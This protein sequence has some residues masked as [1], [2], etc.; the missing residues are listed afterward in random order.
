M[1]EAIPW[2][3]LLPLFWAILA[4]LLGP[5]RGAMPAVTGLAV[6]LAL[7]LLLAASRVEVAQVQD[8]GG[9]DAPLGIEL[10]ADGFSL[11]MLLMT[12]AVALLI[13]LYASAYFTRH[14][15][16]HAYFWPLAGCLIAAMNALYLSSD[17]FNL[18]V[19]LELLSLAAIGLVASEGNAKSAT[20]ALRYLFAS[21]MGSGAYLLGVA[22]LYGAYGTVSLPHLAELMTHGVSAI[23]PYSAGLMLLGLLL[24]TALFPLHFWLPPAHGGA[25]APVSAL[26]SALVIKASFYLALRLWTTLFEPVT[27]MPA[28]QLLGMLG[29]G[30]VLWGSFQALRQRRLKMLVAYSTVAQIGYLFLVFPLLTGSIQSN[31]PSAMQGVILQAVSHGFAKAAMFG[32]A[33]AVILAAGHDELDRLGGLTRHLPVPMFTFAIAGVSLMGLPPSGGFIAK[34]LL[35]D[36]A[37]IARQWWWVA[38]LLTGGLLTAT[39]V[40]KVMRLTFSQAE[41]SAPLHP[42]PKLL[43]WSAMA[44][45]LVSLLLG[46]GAGSLLSLLELA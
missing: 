31:E 10:R 17:I 46:L 27:I 18:Y 37:I 41:P 25:P 36:S 34:W 22:L 35:I 14:A 2:L 4:F 1:T 13:A 28:A 21:M 11:V 9:W 30:A 39:Y 38:V 20:A 32:A 44:L 40:F 24:K 8:V 15:S 5:C 7:T 12:Q 3:I 45:A 42:L 26:L 16:G 29:A 19:T 33:G 6:Q 23:V 43:E